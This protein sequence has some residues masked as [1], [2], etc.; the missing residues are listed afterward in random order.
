MAPLSGP[1]AYRP[2]MIKVSG[3][4][5]GR[6]THTSRCGEENAKCSGSNLLDPPNASSQ[7]KQLFR[8]SSPSNVISSHA[9]ST[10]S[11]GKLRFTSGGNALRQPDR[12]HGCHRL[13]PIELTCQCRC[14]I[15]TLT[16]IHDDNATPFCQLRE[17]LPSGRGAAI[18]IK[19]LSPY[20]AKI[21]FSFEMRRS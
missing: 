10:S 13:G 6:R 16:H 4:T 7:S 5:I 15:H 17:Q 18:D 9:A 19:R 3:P 14:A 20:L 12:R 21:L 1:N 11:L 2:L 8:T